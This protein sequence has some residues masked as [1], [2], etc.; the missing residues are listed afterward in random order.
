M[1]KKTIRGWTE[2]HNEI[3]GKELEAEEK[4]GFRCLR[5]GTTLVWDIGQDVYYAIGD[6]IYK[7]K[8][9]NVNCFSMYGIK[10][11][12]DGSVMYL[13]SNKLY[14][15]VHYALTEAAHYYNLNNKR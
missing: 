3:L 15:N 7:G 2:M 4:W 10:M 14:T 5:N 6:T 8:I 12:E 11:K 9:V 13:P 1:K